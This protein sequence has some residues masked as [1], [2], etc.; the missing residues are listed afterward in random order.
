MSNKT[1][2]HTKCMGYCDSVTRATY[3]D[4]G[5]ETICSC[6]QPHLTQVE[7]VIL[8]CPNGKPRSAK[9][10][11]IKACSCRQYKCVT[12]PDKSSVKEVDAEGNVIE[13]NQENLRR[14]RR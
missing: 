12:R 4:V 9:F 11:I 10:A 8:E 5:Y 3:G 6:C 2:Q 1:Y 14:R 7:T 13:S